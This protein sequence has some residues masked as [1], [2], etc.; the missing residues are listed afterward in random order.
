MA[1]RLP[2]LRAGFVVATAL[3]LRL[4]VGGIVL[5]LAKHNLAVD[6]QSLQHDV[7]T[8]A[9]LMRECSANREPEVVL[10]FA[11]DDGV[12]TMRG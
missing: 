8:V 2:A 10:A 5:Q 4:L 1:G 7:V 9:V 6:R 3:R 11:F 12:S